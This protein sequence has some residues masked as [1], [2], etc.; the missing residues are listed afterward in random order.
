MRLR[1]KKYVHLFSLLLISSFCSYGLVTVM[2]DTLSGNQI[3]YQ[4]TI[5]SD[6][7]G[8]TDLFV[9]HHRVEAADTILYFEGSYNWE[10][11]DPSAFYSFNLNETIL[12]LHLG[13]FDE[14]NY[15]TVVRIAREGQPV[16]EILIN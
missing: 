14:G 5:T 6:F 15:I 7:S 3:G 13:Y 8:V 11:E 10:L 2:Q 1:S 16:E 9:E 4:L 12:E